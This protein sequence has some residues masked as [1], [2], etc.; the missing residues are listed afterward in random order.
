MN[1]CN[2]CDRE[3]DPSYEFVEEVELLESV[4]RYLDVDNYCPD[5]LYDLDDKLSDFTDIW[6]VST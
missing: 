3:Y 4:Q 5:C 1:K 6:K 2:K